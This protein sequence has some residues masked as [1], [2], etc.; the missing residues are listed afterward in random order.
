M[1]AV[2]FFRDTN[3]AAVTSLENTLYHETAISMKVLRISIHLAQARTQ[4]LLLVA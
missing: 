4:A 1:A 2:P 3:M